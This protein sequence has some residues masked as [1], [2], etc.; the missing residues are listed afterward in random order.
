MLRAVRTQQGAPERAQLGLEAARSIVD[1]GVNDTGVVTCL[2]RCELLLLLEHTH[3]DA[4]VASRQLSCQGQA[5]DAA[6]HDT[7][8]E[9]LHLVVLS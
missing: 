3:A 6:A 4:R 5:D 8:R 7:D 9:L 1:A 2:V